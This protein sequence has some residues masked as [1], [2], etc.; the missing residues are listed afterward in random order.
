MA[1]KK[2]TDVPLSTSPTLPTTVSTLAIQHVDPGRVKAVLAETELGG[3][4]PFTL[5]QMR[6]PNGLTWAVPTEGGGEVPMQ[7]AD[8]IL[9]HYHNARTYYP[10]PYDAKNPTHEPPQCASYD[11]VTGYGTPGGP[12][13]ACPLGIFGGPCDPFYFVFVL[14]PDAVMPLKLNIPKTSLSNFESYITM[15]GFMGQFHNE[16]LTRIGLE[17]RR[18]GQGM[19]A[20][21]H[22]LASLPDAQAQTARSYAKMIADSLVYPPSRDI[23]TSGDPT[24]PRTGAPKPPQHP[25]RYHVCMATCEGEQHFEDDALFG[26]RD[27]FVRRDSTGRLVVTAYGTARPPSPATPANDADDIDDRTYGHVGKDEGGVVG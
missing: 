26:V 5:K 10:E 4:N 2:I 27:V 19:V 1:T 8:V 23:A 11:G 14:F 22:M 20:T 9:L 17:K 15:L 3:L 24:R 21:F 6:V 13:K 16:V 12:C 25:L 7:Y 18:K